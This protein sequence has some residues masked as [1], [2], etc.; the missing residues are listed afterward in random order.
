MNDKTMAKTM[1]K[2]ITKWILFLYLLI[3]V[4]LV[5]FRVPVANLLD[6]AGVQTMLDKW[7]TA[8][9]EPLHT[10][11]L[12]W[13]WNH[14]YWS[15]VNLAGNLLVFVPLGMLLPASFRRM[16]FVKTMAL[17]LVFI[18]AIEFSQLF[19]GLGEFDVDDILLNFLGVLGGYLLYAIRHAVKN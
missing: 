8:N 18:L 17:G 6:N 15:T 12:Y 10:I 13:N 19:T 9:L 5:L 1:P 14:H 7:S 4:K 11:K 16:G 3:V 2:P